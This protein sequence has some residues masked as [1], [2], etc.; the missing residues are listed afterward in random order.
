M[1]KDHDQY[2]RELRR[3]GYIT[4]RKIHSNHLRVF[5]SCGALVSTHP[6]NGGSDHRGLLNFKAEVRRH[7]LWHRSSAAA[8]QDDDHDDDQDQDQHADADVHQA[9]CR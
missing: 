1:A 4:V 8:Q 6:V 9:P 3:Q 5:C 7:E 2:L